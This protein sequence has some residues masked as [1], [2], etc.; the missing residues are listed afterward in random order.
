LR[1][2]IIKLIANYILQH[3]REQLYE[4]GEFDPNKKNLIKVI[5]SIHKLNIP[6]YEIIIV[7]NIFIE[8]NKTIIINF[9][10]GSH[11]II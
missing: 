4:F 9:D 3:S 10:D 5:N 7:G 1:E 2:N 11:K 8:S 6:N